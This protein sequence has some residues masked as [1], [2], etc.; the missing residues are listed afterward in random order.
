MLPTYVTS[1]LQ[2]AARRHCH[3]MF[4]TDV[5]NTI[6]YTKYIM[7][8]LCPVDYTIVILYGERYCISLKK[9]KEKNGQYGTV[10][11]IVWSTYSPE[12]FT[13]R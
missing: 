5:T 4:A 1:C 8:H 6:L 13:W 9:V 2:N 12:P 7:I 3:I 11:T 10:Y